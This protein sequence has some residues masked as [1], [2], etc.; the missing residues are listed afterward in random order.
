MNRFRTLCLVAGIGV[1]TAACGSS[2]NSAGGGGSTSSAAPTGNPTVHV[3][4][5]SFNPG[6]VTVKSGATVTWVFDDSAQHNVTAT[7]HA[8]A[9]SDL[10]SGGRYT[11]AFHTPGRYSYLCTIHQYMTGTV[12]VTP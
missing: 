4:N 10:H 6:T 3:K 11:F 5:F 7:G 8:F 2:G 1:A 12:V 9:S